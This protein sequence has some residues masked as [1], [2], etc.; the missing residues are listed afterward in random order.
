[1]SGPL[2]FAGYAALFNRR[3][4]GRDTIRPGAFAQTLADRTTPLPLYW[5]HRPDLRIGWIAQ[6]HEDA[7]GLRVIAVIDNPAGRAAAD[8]N[9]G[10]VTGLSFGYRAREFTRDAAGRN[11][12]GIDLFEISLVT[13]PMQHGAR[14]HLVA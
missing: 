9:R 4:A 7:R 2:R 14:V 12:T 10:T 1:M 3:D 11:L 5:Q 13:H 6:A 8:L